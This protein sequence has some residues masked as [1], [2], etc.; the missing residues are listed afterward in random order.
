TIGPR[1]GARASGTQI[2]WQAENFRVANRPDLRLVDGGNGTLRVFERRL[3]LA[4][5]IDLIEGQI[6]YQPAP[7]GELGSDVVV[8]GRK[9][10]IE[11][12]NTMA[13]LPL[14]LDIDVNLGR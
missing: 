12:E 9:T 3:A 5:R 13:D 10:R 8:V 14:T 2:A 1:S 7:P 6:Q 11:R 4:G